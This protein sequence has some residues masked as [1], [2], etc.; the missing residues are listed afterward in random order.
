MVDRLF[1]I[2][3]LLME[4]Q[5]ITAKELAQRFEVSER[6][7]YRDL[8]KLTLAGIPV[9]TNRGKNGG[10]SVLPDFVLD[11]TV[12]TTEE[13]TRILESLNALNEV[14]QSQNKQDMSKLQAF[15]GEHHQEWL[16]IEFSSWGNRAEDAQLFEQIKQAILAHQYM[17]ISYSGNQG[18]STERKIKPCKLCFKNQAW[19]LYAYCCLRQDYRFFKLKRMSKVRVLDAYFEPEK[20]GRVLPDSDKSY[21]ENMASTQ[22]TLEISPDMAFRAY[23]ELPDI[24]VADSG[25]LVCTITVTDIN[26]FTSYVLSYGS[27]IQVLEPPEIKH[28][29][30]Q[31]IEAM[32]QRYMTLK[33]G[34]GSYGI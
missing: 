17:E 25:N 3:Y 27:H 19:Y 22:V 5:Q 6:T 12:L 31:E 10:I 13:K 14:T 4:K 16:E 26:W 24:K 9:Y 21:S 15:L 8:D 1:Q 7:I 30:M 29:V 20:I 34:D 2:I 23:E 28:K 33:K 11:K 32:K 18:T